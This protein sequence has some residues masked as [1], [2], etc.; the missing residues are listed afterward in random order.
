MQAGT[1]DRHVQFCSHVLPMP[2]KSP[3]PHMRV[4]EVGEEIAVKYLRSLGYQIYSRNV[5]L[6]KDEIDIIAYD[7]SDKVLV[8]A[9]VKT[10]TSSNENFRPEFNFTYF[11]K[12]KLFRAVRKWISQN[13]FEDGFRVDLISVAGGKVVDHFKEITL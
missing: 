6:G 8:F 5:R 7:P 10:R 9:E 12:R 1:M 11:K 3:A 4:G 2:N 13:D